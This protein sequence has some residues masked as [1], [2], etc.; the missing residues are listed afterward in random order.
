M[1]R[2]E[3]VGIERKNFPINLRRVFNPVLLV[4]RQ[5]RLKPGLN[6]E[7]ILTQGMMTF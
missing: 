6:G 2:V 7:T 1:Q 4:E 5:A 3:I